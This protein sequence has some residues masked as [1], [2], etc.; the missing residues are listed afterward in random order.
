[1]KK[2]IALRLALVMVATL[3]LLTGC[4]GDPLPE[5]MEGDATLAAAR[6][7]V[8][9]LNSGAYQEIY[10]RM[11]DDG[12]AGTSVEGIEEYMQ[13]F[14]DTVGGYVKETDRKT[15]GRVLESTDEE[16]GIVLIYCKHE[17]KDAMYRI[18]ISMDME[19]M[20]FEAI[21]N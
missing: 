10:D 12:Q 13:T 14:L 15:T 9:L 5:E 7:V 8:T 18:A 21:K 1:M 19:L 2:K 17:K 4:H 11:R 16:Y 3:F 6:E 20:G